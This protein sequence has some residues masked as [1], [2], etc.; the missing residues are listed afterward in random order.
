M[1][2]ETKNNS[3]IAI[4]GGGCF[5]CTEAVFKS[6]KGVL[7]VIPGYTGGLTIKPTY[8]Q[9]SAGTTG[10][11]ESIRIMF[12]PRNISFNDLL[13]VFFYTH[14]PTTPNRQGNDVG[15]EYQSAIFYTN[16]AQRQEAVAFIA[17]LNSSQAYDKPVITDV[18][19]AETFYEAEDYHREYYLHHQDAPYCQFVI[20]PKLEKLRKK[21]AELMKN[22]K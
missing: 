10:H 20:E 9:V 18:R 12:D 8:E 15:T 22:E 6:L 21:F 13:T 19:P 17:E 16:E 11:V 2:G 5:W 3:E 1:P 14:D 7:S 4:F